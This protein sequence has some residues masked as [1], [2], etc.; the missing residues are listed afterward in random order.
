LG[1]TDDII[2]FS[3]ASFSALRATP[4]TGF[5]PDK[6]TISLS[7][8]TFTTAK[9]NDLFT[10]RSIAPTGN[11]KRDAAAKKKLAANL[12]HLGTTGKSFVYNQVKGQPIY[13]E[14]SKAPGFGDGGVFANFTDK[15]LLTTSDLLLA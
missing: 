2:N 4:V 10:A 3:A 11:K 12:K 15:P 9:N 6:D 13:D 5:N 1:T 7:R 8:T 14:S